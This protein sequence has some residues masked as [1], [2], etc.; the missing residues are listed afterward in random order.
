MR[1][2]L[3][4]TISLVVAA[5]LWLPSIRLFYRPPEASLRPPGGVSPLARSL[6]RRHLRLWTVPTLRAREIAR[7][8]SSNAEW[9]FMGRTYLVLAL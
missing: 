7:M 3:I 6:A 9:D 1:R 2:I 4:A 5:A 8:R